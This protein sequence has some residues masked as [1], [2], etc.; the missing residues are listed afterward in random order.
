MK[1]KATYKKT[2]RKKVSKR[3]KPTK[4]SAEKALKESQN[5]LET[6]INSVPQH[7]FWKDI[8]SVFLGCNKNFAK[9]V[10]LNSPE[11]IIGK[12]DFDL[13]EKE[14]AQHFVDVDQEVIKSNKPIYGMREA[15]KNA[16]G[17][18]RWLDVNKVPFYD[19]NGNVTGIIGTFEDVTAKVSLAEKLEKNAQKYKSLIDQTNTAYIIMD[20]KLQITETNEIFAKMLNLDIEEILGKSPRSWIS[21]EHI[22][23]FDIYFNSLLLEGKSINNLELSLLN[24]NN[25]PINVIISA[26]T[27]ENGG[28]IIFCLLRDISDKKGVEKKKYIEQQK[29]KD[30]L[31]QNILEIRCKLREIRKG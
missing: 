29:K 23:S 11:E 17:E 19:N 5:M 31:K 3:T 6:V 26:N 21:H 27:I 30:K 2:T 8:N 15:Y 14:K 13:I 7:I 24:R 10:G 12:T 16:D 18:P 4:T 22:E 20:S 25:S 28:K 1:K 9:A